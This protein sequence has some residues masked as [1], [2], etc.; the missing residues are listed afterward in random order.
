MEHDVYAPSTRGEVAILVLAGLCLLPFLG[1]AWFAHPYL[2]DFIF[3]LLVRQNGL[4]S[5][6][7]TMYMTWQG[8]Y[9]ASFITA[10]HP[11]A[12]GG[13]THV[14]PF[15]FGFI[16]AVA[17][18]IL[19][20]GAALL[21]G[22]RGA[23]VKR[24]AAGSLVLAL[25][26]LML[27]SP[28]EAFYWLLSG[29]FYMGGASCCFLLLGTIGHLHATSGRGGRWAWWL[30]A[31]VLTLLAPGFSEMISCFVLA[32]VIVLLPAIW[33]R[34]LATSWLSLLVLAVVA[35]AV[36]TLAPG[37][38]VRQAGAH[39]APLLASVVLASASLV[40]TLVSWL[41]NGMLLLL[42]LLILPT[43]ARLV[44]LPALPLAQLTKWTWRWPLW[45]MLG[46]LLCYLFSYLT[47]GGPPPS[48]ARNLLFALFLIGWFLSVAGIVARRLRSK[49]PAAP[50][51]PAYTKA[52][53]TALFVL[54]VV[55]DHNFSLKR[56]Q[57]GT[58]TNSVAQAY[59]DWLSGDAAQYD[60]EEEG[61]Y[62]LIR[63][64]PGDSVALPALSKQPVT[65]VWW[66]ISANPLQWG[67][68]AYA[69]FFHK[70]AIWVD[71]Q[72]PLEGQ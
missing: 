30:L 19:F 21:R 36:A 26:L 22:L 5:H 3:P 7:V 20:A 48:R 38:F 71:E 8:R 52:V 42:T 27:P 18:S 61:R 35:S 44:A 67:N 41:S 4:W 40:Y 28:T 12:W 31:T 49:Q 68:Q 58:P 46:L 69:K 65:L 34:Q 24:A 29:L 16:V 47:I 45:L 62:A 54:A 25:Q 17:A 39:H 64:S 55:T 72:R 11:L 59:H 53:L 51:L 63:R 6:T 37:N 33:Q 13:L 14:Q 10:L 43:V 56:D 57:V 32:G 9:S 15:T 66:D 70:R 60:R 1:L 23:W 2:D 50:A